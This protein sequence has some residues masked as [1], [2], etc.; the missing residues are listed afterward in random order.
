M[1]CKTNRNQIINLVFEYGKTLFICA[2]EV[3][4]NKIDTI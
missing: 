2:K 4:W 1:V 3:L